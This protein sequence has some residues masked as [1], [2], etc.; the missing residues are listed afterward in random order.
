MYDE[1]FDVLEIFFQKP[2]AAPKT[3]MVALAEDVYA[4]VAPGTQRVVALTIHGFRG[5]ARYGFSI[6]GEMNLTTP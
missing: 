1:Q 5:V 6:E 2:G 3:L 4:R